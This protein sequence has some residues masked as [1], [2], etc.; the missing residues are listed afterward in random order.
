MRKL[1]ALADLP[2]AVYVLALAHFL[3]H[4][5]T[6]GN[7]G[8]FRDEL[9]YLACADH[10][11]WGYVDQPPL[12]IAV[13]AAVRAVAGESV[14]AIRLLPSLAGAALVVLAAL[15]ARELGGGRW[16]QVL[17]ALAVAVTPEYLGLTGFYSMNALDLLFWACAILVLIRLVKTG[18]PK[19]WLAFGAIAGLGLL[20]KISL[21]FLGFAVAV[22]VALTPLRRHLRSPY[23]WLGALL[24]LV[25]FLPHVAWQIRHGWPTLEFIDNASRYKIA[26]LGPLEFLAAQVLNM[27]PLNLPIW[28]GGLAFLL[29]GREGRRFRALAIVFL[30]VLVVLVVQ[31]SKPYYL[32]AAFPPLFAAGA[33]ACERLTER[34]F[35]ARP[36][37]AGVLAVGGALTAPFAV[38]VLPVETLVAYQGALGLAPRAAENSELGALPQH[39]ADRFGWPELARAVAEVYRSLP[40][41]ER[42]DAMIVTSNYGQAG[43]LRYFGDGLPPAASQHNSFFFWGPGAGS[44]DVVITVGMDPDDEGLRRTFESVVFVR[45]AESSPYAM[46][47]ERRAAICVCRGLR[48]PLAE[49]WRQGK[50]F[51]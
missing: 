51:I 14:L 29:F 20:N 9:Y 26:A 33:I 1:Q 37:G 17:A 2:P 12:S 31:N 40:P 32:A 13:L 34:R 45:R 39:F 23:L 35:W 38:P 36:F 15:M 46:P 47:Y 18:D 10:L 43:A 6:S 4:V 11:D 22:A 5:A 30:A 7:Y 3:L 41:G 48:I 50:K 27:H 8:I 24:A 16:A 49:A 21:L 25:L 42:R 44:G 28:L 19:L